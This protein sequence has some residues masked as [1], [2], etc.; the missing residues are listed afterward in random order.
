M[1]GIGGTTMVKDRITTIIASATPTSLDRRITPTSLVQAEIPDLRRTRLLT[2]DELTSPIIRC[3][4]SYWMSRQEHGGPMLR[5]H[6]DAAEIPH[7]LPHL[8]L[9]EVVQ[10]PD[11]R[12]IALRERQ[13]ESYQMEPYQAEPM[14]G[15]AAIVPKLNFR[16]RIIGEVLQR[17]S[18]GNYTG[19]YFSEVDGQGPG[20]DVWRVCSEV[21]LQRRP[22]LLRPPYVGPHS[23]IFYC[24]SATMPLVDDEGAVTRLLIA[25]DFLPEAADDHRHPL[26]HRRGYASSPPP[27]PPPSD[28]APLS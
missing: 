26:Q 7:L 13:A 28:S 20:S 18:R 22:L 8:L 9:L 5:R 1:D 25:C 16:Y 27:L 14:N 3:A 24:E 11:P 19:K 6:L 17:Y 23:Q 10:G 12:A 21:T 4:I 2:F 15:P